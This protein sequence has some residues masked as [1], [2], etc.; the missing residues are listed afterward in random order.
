[1][2]SLFVE[3]ARTRKRRGRAPQ[4][5]PTKLKKETEMP[6]VNKYKSV[7]VT[8]ESYKKLCEL[9]IYTDRPIGKQLA[10]LIE[11]AYQK[12]LNEVPNAG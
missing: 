9:S 7:G 12:A 4:T 11:Q 10:R 2:V 8:I 6:N 3:F 1:M 5:P